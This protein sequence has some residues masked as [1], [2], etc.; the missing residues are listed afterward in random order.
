MQQTEEAAAETKAQRRRAFWL[1]EQRGVIQAQFAERIT[2]RFIVVRADR[3][4]TGINL[5]LHFFKAWQRFVCRVTRGGQGVPYRRAEDVFNRTDQPA[6]FTAVKLGTVNLLRGEDAE[7]VSVIH[8]AS[9]QNLNFI[10]LAHGAVFNPHQR[11]HTEVVT[12]PG[13]DNQRLQR[14][15]RIAFWRRDVTH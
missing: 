9:T 5:R 12:E 15:F 1:I 8:L 10:A 7:T 14:C 3:E 11:H 6:N 13:V 4:Q 2:E